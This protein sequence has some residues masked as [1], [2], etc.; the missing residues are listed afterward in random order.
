MQDQ[1]NESQIVALTITAHDILAGVEKDVNL[2]QSDALN[3][4]DVQKLRTALHQAKELLSISPERAKQA[5]AN[6][7][8]SVQQSIAAVKMNLALQPNPYSWACT[9][10]GHQALGGFDPITSAYMKQT[11]RDHFAQHNLAYDAWN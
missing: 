10:F 3:H 6:L 5:Q 11:L 7:L 8:Q 2:H 1:I 4:D 9:N